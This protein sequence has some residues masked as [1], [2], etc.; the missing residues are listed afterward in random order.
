MTFSPVRKPIARVNAFKRIFVIFRLLR[1]LNPAL[2]RRRSA[3]HRRPACTTVAPAS[4]RQSRER[5]ALA[6]VSEDAHRTAAG[7]ARYKIKRYN[8]TKLNRYA[9]LASVACNYSEFIP[10]AMAF[11]LRMLS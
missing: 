2:H 9:F 1:K 4:C 10:S 11:I 5:L 7:T 6:T 8:G 3:E